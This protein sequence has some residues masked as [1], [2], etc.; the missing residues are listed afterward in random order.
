MVKSRV[1]DFIQEQ[2]SA[3]S[4][5][6]QAEF[7]LVRAGE[8]ASLVTE[9]FALK[10]IARDCRTIH[11]DKGSG[12]AA[13]VMVQHT[14]NELLARAGLSQ[15]KH[16]A[17]GIV[18]H[19]TNLFEKAL[20]RRAVGDQMVHGILMP[21]LLALIREAASK[22]EQ[23]E[24]PIQ[25]L[26]HPV[27]IHGFYDE[28]VGTELHGLHGVLDRPVGGKHDDEGKR[29]FSAAG[30]QRVKAG[31][32]RHLH[33]QEHQ[34]R[35]FLIQ[36][37]QQGLAGFECHDT[38]VPSGKTFDERSADRRLIVGDEDGGVHASVPTESCAGRN[39]SQSRAIVPFPGSLANVM[40]PPCASAIFLQMASPR[41]VPCRFPVVKNG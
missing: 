12:C 5:I 22:R 40:S 24:R 4:P 37:L 31:K 28:I 25:D 23:L 32:A 11:A 41:P 1:A 21:V 8:S 14:G 16:G 3:L 26:F 19:F 6:E 9:Q 36:G 15:H 34:I 30:F 38:M 20:H 29:R 10:E 39:G 17:L 18:G 35:H 27:E 2:G 7:A 13:A 33:I